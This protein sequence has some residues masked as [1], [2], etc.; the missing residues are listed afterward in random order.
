MG[1]IPTRST[2]SE[3]VVSGVLSRRAG[4]RTAASRRRAAPTPAASITSAAVPAA[5]AA[6]PRRPGVLRRWSVAELL[7]GAVVRP[8][9]ARPH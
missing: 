3:S 7:A 2:S 1:Q 5:T 4:T 6:A 9:A 8:P